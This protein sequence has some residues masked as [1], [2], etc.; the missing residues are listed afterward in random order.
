MKKDSL[1]Q[2][3]FTLV[4]ILIVMA[5][6][7]ALAVGMLAAIDPLEQFRKGTDTSIRNTLSEAY[8]GFIRYYALKTMFPW[9]TSVEDTAVMGP[10]NLFSSAGTQYLGDL[11]MAGE[12]KSDFVQMA[13]STRLAQIN[14][15][16]PTGNNVWLC[17]KPGSKGF[18]KD[19]NTYFDSAGGTADSASCKTYGGTVDC[20][21]CM[22]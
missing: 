18:Q 2:L 21:W 13:G 22:K 15:Y 8:N 11:T 16:S 9:Q 17:F 14:L 12:L 10:V 6:L 3:G 1:S 5:L 20:Y 7:G 4:E 19:A